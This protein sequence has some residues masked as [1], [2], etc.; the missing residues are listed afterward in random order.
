MVRFC[1]N[2]TL[3]NLLVQP[4]E[5]AKGIVFSL[6]SLQGDVATLRREHVLLFAR[7]IPVAPRR[8]FPEI[9]KP[10]DVRNDMWVSL[11]GVFSARKLTYHFALLSTPILQVRD[12]GRGRV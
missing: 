9:I 1:V 10:G 3:I 5:K 11:H 4:L 7:N 6:K 8:G 12:A 2:S